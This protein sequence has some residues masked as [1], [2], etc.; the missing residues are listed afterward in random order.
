M[1]LRPPLP[2]SLL[3][4]ALGCV[5]MAGSVPAPGSQ[6]ACAHDLTRY[7][8]YETWSGERMTSSLRGD[9]VFHHVGPDGEYD[10]PVLRYIEPGGAQVELRFSGG[11]FHHL[12]RAGG[13]PQASRLV[14]FIDNPAPGVSGRRTM[15]ARFIAGRTPGAGMFCVEAL[16]G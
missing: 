3:S 5:L 4:V 15:R 12:A 6:E 10:A 2:I 8:S 11:L 13:G 7:L 1:T 16:E 9:G 14:T